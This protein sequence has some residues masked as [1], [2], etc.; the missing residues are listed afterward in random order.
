MRREDLRPETRAAA[1]AAPRRLHTRLTKGE[2]RHRKRMAQVAAVYTVA[3]YPR[4][5]T[6]VLADL[7]PVQDVERDR[8]RPRPTNKRVWAS[9][10]KPAGG[11]IADAFEQARRRD[12]RFRRRWVVL[13]D[14]NR[15][16][17]R[18]VRKTARKLGVVITIVVDLIH[19]LE[20]LWRA[21]YAFHDDGSKEAEP[22]DQRNV[23]R[24]ARWRT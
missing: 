14:G 2:K 4:T 11:V 16:Q 13:V 19:V 8:D 15:D 17:L 21:A 18:I 9:L 22:S 3:P 5:V 23:T 7:R 20:Y 1:E 12:P 6:D 24:W 10:T